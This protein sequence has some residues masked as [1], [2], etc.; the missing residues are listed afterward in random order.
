MDQSKYC[1]WKEAATYTENLL[2]EIRHT[3]EELNT[4]FQGP[5]LSSSSGS[6]LS[7]SDMVNNNK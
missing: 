4:K 3:T 1:V 5:A 2:G 6:M 7:I